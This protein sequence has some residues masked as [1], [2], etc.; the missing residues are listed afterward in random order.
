VFIRVD[1]KDLIRVFI[2][3]LNNGLVVLQAHPPNVE[4]PLD[5]N[6]ILVIPGKTR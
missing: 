5:G 1:E 6:R 3:L 2:G 4:Y